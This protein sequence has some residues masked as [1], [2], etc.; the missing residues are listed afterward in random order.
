MKIIELHFSDTHAVDVDRSGTTAFPFKSFEEGDSKYSLKWQLLENSTVSKFIETYDNIST[1]ALGS[2]PENVR[3]FWNKYTNHEESYDVMVEELNFNTTVAIEKFGEM[4]FS[5]ALLINKNDTQHI[6][7]DKLCKI[8]FS[9]ET[10]M[11][12]TLQPLDTYAAEL[13]ERLNFLVHKLENIIT[14]DDGVIPTYTFY[15]VRIVPTLENGILYKEYPYPVLQDEDYNRFSAT[16]SGDLCLDYFTVGK[17]LG[18]ASLTND[19]DLVRNL[20]I[21]QQSVISSSFNFTIDSLYFKGG[22]MAT[23]SLPSDPPM[24]KAD[25][26]FAVMQENMYK[27]CEENNVGEYYNYRDPM[28]NIGRVVLGTLI[29]NNYSDIVENLKKYP[30]VIGVKISNV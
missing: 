19:T 3:V 5:N 2:H 10:I 16:N 8:H 26:Q 22:G 24:K 1:S 29:N 23:Q 14:S 9:F 20:E 17:D 12:N 28:F 30:L 7:S 27:W 21:K 4:Y 15:I 13:C 11:N 25:K 18:S 6:V